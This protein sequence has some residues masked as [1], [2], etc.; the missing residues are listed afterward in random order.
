MSENENVPSWAKDLMQQQKD[1]L[2]QIESFKGNNTPPPAT[3]PKEE[4][5]EL[6]VPT[7]QEIEQILKGFAK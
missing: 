4:K 2:A 7:K 3:P 1:L 5:K 6:P